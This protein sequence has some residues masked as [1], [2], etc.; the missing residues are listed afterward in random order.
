MINEQ[1]KN[2][3]FLGIGGIGMSALAQY[4]HRAGYAVAGYDRTPSAI[5]QQLSE[6]NI[7]VS[8]NQEVNWLKNLNWNWENTLVVYTPAVD[9]NSQYFTYF[10]SINQHLYKRSQLVGHLSKGYKT[11]A[12]AGTHGKTT[13]SAIVT[14]LLKEAGK[15]IIALVGGVMNNYKNNLIWDDNAEY[16]VVEADE[17]DRSFHS[18]H[19]DA[20]IITSCEPDHLDIYKTDE[21]FYEAFK[22]FNGQINKNGVLVV[23][24]DAVQKLESSTTAKTISYSYSNKSEVSNGNITFAIPSLE[25]S[26]TWKIPGI[27]NIENATAAL[28]LLHELGISI[29]ALQNGLKTF[30]GVHRRFQYHL[31]TPSKILIDDYAHHP[32]E[33]KMVE[34]SCRALYPNKKIQALF[35]PHLFS[36]TKDFMTEFAEAL[37]AFDEQVLL[38]IYPARE[39]PIEDINSSALLEL[40]KGDSKKQVSK[41]DLATA[42]KNSSCEITVMMGAGDINL[43]LPSITK[44]LEV[45][46]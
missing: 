28:I 39:E 38:D 43:L 22:V 25:S 36:R 46:V 41:E 13:T 2:I 1:T 33:I 32:S 18:L 14:H 20:A 17:F 44:E 23:H 40:I 37:S 34:K 4:Y 35:Q 7:T 24:Q 29:N 11:I 16:L 12:I 5:T 10:N 8:H 3:F 15:K 45:S 27:H 19:P 21:A 31:Q 26:F 30:E 9:K 42:V 6:L